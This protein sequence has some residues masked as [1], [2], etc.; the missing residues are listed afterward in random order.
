MWS[1]ADT[2]GRL[3][4]LREELARAIA[5][6]RAGLETPADAPAD[7]TGQHNAEGGTELFLREWALTSQR[8]LERELRA[9][10]DAIARA[11]RGLYGVC[12]ECGRPIEPERLAIRPSAIRRVDCERRHRTAGARRSLPRRS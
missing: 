3:E 8:A 10:E 5:R 4:A 9:V 1:E 7:R 6:S 12:V 2:R 11:E